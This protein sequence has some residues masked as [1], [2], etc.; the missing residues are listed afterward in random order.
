MNSEGEQVWVNLS[1]IYK[2]A[3]EH[4]GVAPEAISLAEY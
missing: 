1:D 4:F 3:A 2:K